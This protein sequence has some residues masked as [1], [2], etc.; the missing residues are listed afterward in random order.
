[1][2]LLKRWKVVLCQL[3]LSLEMAS[4]SL[5]GPPL[6]FCAAQIY[7]MDILIWYSV[8]SAVVG[9]LVGVLAHVGEV[10]RPVKQAALDAFSA[11]R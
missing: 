7:F 3:A 5:Q 2:G 6:R 11:P 4:P 10:W 8:F 1:M 9:F